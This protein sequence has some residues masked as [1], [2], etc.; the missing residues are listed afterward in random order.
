MAHFLG[1]LH[2]PALASAYASADVF[3]FPSRTDT[4]GLVMIE[5]LATGTPVAAFPVHGP[6]DII[7]DA[8]ATIGAMDQDLCAAIRKALTARPAA[9][10]TE[11]R[12][13]SWDA[14]TDQFVAGLSLPSTPEFRR[15]A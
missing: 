6:L 5:A 3:V 10:A 14:C 15:A 8:K 7:G 11:G 13:Y 1:A 4:F 12:R 9:C 2:G